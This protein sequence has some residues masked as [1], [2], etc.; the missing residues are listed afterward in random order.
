MVLRTVV[1]PSMRSL[2]SLAP[3]VF[4]I[5]L[6]SGETG[7]VAILSEI[8]CRSVIFKNILFGRERI[9]SLAVLTKMFRIRQTQ[10]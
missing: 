2:L 7:A 4:S 5:E 3:F 8:C 6:A 10:N 9:E 1:P